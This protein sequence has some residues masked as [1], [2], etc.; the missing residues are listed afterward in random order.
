MNEELSAISDQ[1]IGS[2]EL[3]Q[4]PQCEV[5]TPHAT[6]SDGKKICGLCGTEHE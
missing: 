2:V 4:C 5:S 3:C 1:R 6:L